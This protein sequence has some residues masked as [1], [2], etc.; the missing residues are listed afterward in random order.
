MRNLLRATLFSFYLLGALPA[1]SV[2]VGLL[3]DAQS[4][5][6]STFQQQLETL[7]TNDQLLLVTLDQLDASKLKDV[8]KWVTLGPNALT[9]L[10]AQKGTN[11]APVLSLFLSKAKQEVLRKQ[12]PVGFT[13]LTNAPTIE[14]QLALVKTMVPNANHIG[15]YRST[16]YKIDEKSYDEIAATYGLK[17]HWAKLKDPLDWDRNALKIL[18][19]VDLVLGIDDDALYNTTTIRSILMRLYRSGKALI[20]PDKGYVRAGAVASV[21]SGIRETLKAVAN[22]IHNGTAGKQTLNN[23]Y[24]N[25]S[26]N[27]QVARSLN[28]VVDDEASLAKQVKERLNEK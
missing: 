1:W 16:T 8:Q 6:I 21:Y 4:K 3:V 9:A 23:P 20:G 19:N 26:V 27:A 25:V 12:Y 22:W 13:V 18:N 15:V 5:Q 14:R 11:Q 10:M 7:L 24:F 28:I 17:L 2:T